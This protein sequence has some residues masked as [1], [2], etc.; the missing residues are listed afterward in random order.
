MKKDKHNHVQA[1]RDVQHFGEEGGVVPVIDV[2]A[3]STF[4]HPKD[5]E[6]VFDG[7]LQGCYLYSRHSNPTVNMFGKKLAAMDAAEAALGVSSGMAAICCTL[8]QICS[9]GDHIIASDTIYGGSYALFAHLFP[10]K[11]IEVSFVDI[12]N[13]DKVKACVKPNTKV[14]Y[15]ET[16][17]NPMLAVAD[18]AGL[19]KITVANHA[20]LVI[21]NTFMPSIVTPIPLGADIVVYS[22]TKYISGASD[23]IAGAIVGSSDFISSLLDIN[24]G[25][26]MLTGPVLDP[27]ISHELYMRLDHL[28]VRMKAHSDAALYFAEKLEE[29]GLKPVYP[30][31]KSHTSHKLLADQVN[32]HT[33]FG[34]MVALN[35]G[36]L[37]KARSLAEKLQNEKFAL[38]A[39]SL[40]FSRTLVSIP[41][42]STSSEIPAEDREKLGLS[43]GILRFS[44]GYLGDLEVMTK[45]FFKCFDEIF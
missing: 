35:V 33:G 34:G 37:E 1:L 15:A 24:S 26:V 9:Q 14:I 13:L 2:A 41:A 20:Q 30:G 7:E 21:D 11:G 43:D 40:G 17:S 32:A 27:R 28:P 3:T 16:V 44:I 36:S 29:R 39:V 42:A 12:A 5:M 4:M 38:F 18:I 10:R 8:E 45:R 23:L 19:K 22:C 6:R 31:L 25:H